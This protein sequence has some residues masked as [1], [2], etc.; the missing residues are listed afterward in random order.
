[1]LRVSE[2]RAVGSG[3]GGWLASV[4]LQQKSKE[5]R[6]TPGRLLLLV[7]AFFGE[8][9]DGPGPTAGNYWAVYAVRTDG[10]YVLAAA[11]PTLERAQAARDELTNLADKNP[12]AES[13]ARLQDWLARTA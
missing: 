10:K 7:T 8:V 2:P 3:S 6:W 5:P 4:D 13:I 9:F 11:C 1:M 12:E